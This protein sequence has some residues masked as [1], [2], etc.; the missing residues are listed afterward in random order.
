MSASTLDPKPDLVLRW[1]ARLSSIPSVLLLAFFVLGG[2]E[3]LPTFHEAAPLA[4]FPLGVVVGM[5]LGWWHEGLGG[6]MTILSLAVFYLWM[7]VVGGA[8]PGGPYFLLFAA[9]GFLFF[10]AWWAGQTRPSFVAGVRRGKGSPG[11]K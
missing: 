8:F 2:K 7:L 11:T 6:L 5:V 4:F 3:R 1:V 10:A 9:P